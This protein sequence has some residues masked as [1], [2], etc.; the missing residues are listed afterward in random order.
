MG[1]LD[2]TFA[3]IVSL[4][5]PARSAKLKGMPAGQHCEPVKSDKYA[6]SPKGCRCKDQNGY[7]RLD[8]QWD[9]DGV[10]VFCSKHIW[11]MKRN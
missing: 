1:N 3:V 2:S 4:I 5:R 7:K 9:K 11:S 10:C 6:P 8:H